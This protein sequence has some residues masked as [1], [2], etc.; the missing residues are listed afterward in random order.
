M[1]QQQVQK[2]EIKAL[3]KQL[4]LLSNRA[5]LI[6]KGKT[7]YQ[8]AVRKRHQ[9]MINP[10]T[11]TAILIS[12]G[13]A[14]KIGQGKYKFNANT[15]EKRKKTIR[16]KI[17]KLKNQQ[18]KP[19][20]ARRKKRKSSDDEESSSE[21]EEG[22]EDEYEEESDEV[23]QDDTD[24]VSYY[25]HNMADLFSENPR[26]RL[27]V[28]DPIIEAFEEF[29]TKENKESSRV[30]LTDFHNFMTHKLGYT[31]S[32]PFLKKVMEYYFEKEAENDYDRKFRLVNSKKKKN[33]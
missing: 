28:I 18:N 33:K 14:I 20:R 6:Q 12:A 22:D 24:F 21:D 4:A 10:F 13:A 19:P 32:R 16:N 15:I 3:K 8:K 30:V 7:D 29:Q 2:R 11:D 31:I 5:D 23:N 17:K 9:C 25:N 27:N 1:A 26:L